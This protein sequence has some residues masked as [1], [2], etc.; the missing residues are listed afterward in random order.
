MNA[1]GSI[2]WRGSATSFDGSLSSGA[3]RP[4][5]QN[6]TGGTTGTAAPGTPPAARPAPVNVN[7]SIT[8][9]VLVVGL[10]LFIWVIRKGKKLMA[11]LDDR[12]GGFSVEELQQLRAEGKISHA[13]YQRAMQLIADQY[14][15]GGGEKKR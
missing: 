11:R 12:I 13:E 14:S 15:H 1:A 10:I 5:A 4:L 6:T 3:F 9:P 8:A 7:P 2:T